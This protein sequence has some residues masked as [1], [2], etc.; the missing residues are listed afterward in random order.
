MIQGIST[1]IFVDDCVQINLS[2]TAVSTE[3]ISTKQNDIMSYLNT[4]V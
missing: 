2:T 3:I 1:I 4:L